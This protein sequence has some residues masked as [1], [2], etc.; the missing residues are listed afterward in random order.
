MASLCSVRSRDSLSSILSLV[1]FLTFDLVENISFDSFS[2]GCKIFPLMVLVGLWRTIRHY[3]LS[4]LM[5]FLDTFW[6]EENHFPSTLLVDSFRFSPLWGSYA[7]SF[8]S[9]LLEH[10]EE[11]TFS[12]LLA[13]LCYNASFLDWSE[14]HQDWWISV[15]RSSVGES[16]N[17][18]RTNQPGGLRATCYTEE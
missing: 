2:L 6:L 9:V 16:G 13:R 14:T 1:W 15:S 17:F 11:V 7:V 8:L 3:G 12:F 18:K 10:L 5:V 4:G